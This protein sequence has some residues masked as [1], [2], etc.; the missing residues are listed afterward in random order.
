MSADDFAGA[1]TA[2]P[3]GDC[4]SAQPDSK[5]EWATYLI[6]TPSGDPADEHIVKLTAGEDGTLS[7]TD[8]AGGYLTAAVSGSAVPL[9]RG[10]PGS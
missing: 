3:T 8:Q 5:G 10:G 9:G 4:A 7:V 1:L 2:G 6:I